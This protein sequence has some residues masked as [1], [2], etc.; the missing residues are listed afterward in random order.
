MLFDVWVDHPPVGEKAQDR[1]MKPSGTDVTVWQP[2]VDQCNQLL[3][4]VN[5]KLI[6]VNLW[7][8]G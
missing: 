7:D 3:P 1:N 6:A 4:E 2:M 5:E 8:K